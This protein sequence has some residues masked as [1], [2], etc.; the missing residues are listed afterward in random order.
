M[1]RHI[2]VVMRILSLVVKN[3]RLME[4]YLYKTMKAAMIVEY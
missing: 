2:A 1:E 3:G 4:L